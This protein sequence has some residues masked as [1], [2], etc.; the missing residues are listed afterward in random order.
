MGS[1]VVCVKACRVH[2]QHAP[3]PPAPV[4]CLSLHKAV[5]VDG[6]RRLIG[7][8]ALHGERLAGAGSYVLQVALDL[9]K[10]DLEWVDVEAVKLVFKVGVEPE[11]GSVLNTSTMPRKCIVEHP[12]SQTVTLTVKHIGM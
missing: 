2:L 8:H 5:G 7:Q 1:V 6:G 12:S 3:Y 9:D 4:V 11:G 10:K